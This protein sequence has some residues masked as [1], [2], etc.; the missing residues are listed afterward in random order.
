MWKPSRNSMPGHTGQTMQLSSRRGQIALAIFQELVM[1]NLNSPDQRKKG[2]RMFSST[3]S[4]NAPQTL[5]ARRKP[6]PAQICSLL[7]FSICLAVASGGS[8]LP[9]AVVSWGEGRSILEITNA[10]C[11]AFGFNHALAQKID[12]TVVG[13]GD[14]F[15]GETEA[16]AGVTDAKA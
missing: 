1:L 12:G 2:H 5:G 15:T 7:F 13:L 8:P 14:K 3:P 11:I 4:A 9:L 10:R 16:L 6:G